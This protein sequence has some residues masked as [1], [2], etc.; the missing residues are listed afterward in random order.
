MVLQDVAMTALTKSMDALSYNVKAALD[1]ADKAQSASLALGKTYEETRVQL[2]G[3]IE[4]LRGDINQRFQAG[5]LGLEAGLQGNTA[6]VAKLINQQQLTRT[7]FGKTADTVA[8]L[9][10]EL[11]LSRNDTNL[12]SKNLI[13]TGTEYTIST[14]KLVGAIDA[15][16]ATFPAQKLAGMGAEVMEAVTLLQGE[17][18]P[19][20]AGPLQNVMKMVM[21]SSLQGYERLQLLGIEDVRGR[22]AA[23]KSSVEAQQ[24]LKDAFVTASDRF[25][26]ISGGVN[27]SF[28]NIAAASE[29]FGSQTIQF[30]TIADNLGKRV[31]EEGKEAADFGKTLANLKKEA[32]VP[33]Q[34][35]FTVAYPFLLEAVDLLSAI[36]NV[37]GQRFKD[38]AESLGGEAGAAKSMKQFKLFIV[39]VAT[40]GIVKFE[41]V[42]GFMNKFITEVIPDYT[43]SLLKPFQNFTG[44]GG[45]LDKIKLGFFEIIGTMAKIIEFLALG[46]VG[47]IIGLKPLSGGLDESIEKLND[48]AALARSRPMLET[49]LPA[50]AVRA[51]FGEGKSLTESTAGAFRDA[52]ANNKSSEL[53]MMLEGIKNDINDD[54]PLIRRSTRAIE[55]IE[56]KTPEIK[57]QSQFLDETANMLG[58]SIEG[59]LGIGRDSTAAEMLEELKVANEQRAAQAAKSPAEYIDTG[60]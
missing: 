24:I 32:L 39:D 18:G 21:D 29:T 10:A 12:L 43:N 55:E 45:T 37:V 38:F 11:G 44:P 46:F 6:G 4:G 1:F 7:A 35:A 15:L 16:K 59:I 47:K 14:D 41:T 30:T 34:E 27:T 9:E 50:F 52:V 3:T 28:L 56:R 58:R 48:R 8:S 22:L 17:L 60:G 19:Q 36:I 5:I 13:Q 2:G 33:F 57:T 23:A 51:L 49:L 31:R 20:L 26:S 54:K 53:Y 40:A 25:K 42:F